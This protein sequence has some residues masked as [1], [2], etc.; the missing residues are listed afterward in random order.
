[1][2]TTPIRK[3]AFTLIE[4]L[5][6]I[7]II[8]ILAGLLLPALSRAKAKAQRIVC[9]N[10]LKQLGLSWQLYLGDNHDVLVPNNSVKI[11]GQLSA[12]VSW[13]LA[14]PTEAGVSNGM[15]FAYT[16]S[17]PI[18]HCPSDRSTLTRSRATP[19]RGWW[20]RSNPVVGDP[21]GRTKGP[22]RAR[23]YTMSESVNGYPDYNLW[24]FTNIPMFKK[25]T[26]IRDPYPSKCLVFIDEHEYTLTDS[27]FGMPT[28][29]SNFV[30]NQHYPRWWDILISNAFVLSLSE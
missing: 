20:H 6:V 24:V 12:G 1:M 3:W 5:V 25:L 10:N 13:C 19:P 15:L 21:S 30:Q 26:E 8:A 11:Y 29:Y 4:L 17:F 16:R 7:A 14:E 9:N 28:D 22:L 23:S 18:Y 27:V 2:K